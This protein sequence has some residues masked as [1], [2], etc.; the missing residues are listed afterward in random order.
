MV[1]LV[2]LDSLLARKDINA[3]YVCTPYDTQADLVEK[4][5]KYKKKILCEKPLLNCEYLSKVA[6]ERDQ[7]LVIAFHR[8]LKS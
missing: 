1:N 8:R 3:I 2:Q 6:S 7:L 4:A 5:L